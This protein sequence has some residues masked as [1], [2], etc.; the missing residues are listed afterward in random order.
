MKTVDGKDY[1]SIAEISELH[2]KDRRYL[3][4]DFA[5][6]PT[7][8][9]KHDVNHKIIPYYCFED[10]LDWLGTTDTDY[11]VQTIDGIDYYRVSYLS[12]IAKCSYHTITNKY[13]KYCKKIKHK[14]KE[15]WYVNICVVRLLKEE[16]YR[17]Q[18]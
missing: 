6:Y 13:S 17:F 15:K 10:Y 16:G 9:L 4:T 11:F 5:K 7:T 1:I 8:L 18:L 2:G 3:C 12:S 14:N